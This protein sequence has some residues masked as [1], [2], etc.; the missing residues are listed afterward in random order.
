MIAR[1]KIRTTNV[2]II[3]KIGVK[4]EKKLYFLLNLT[5]VILNTEVS[6]CHSIPPFPMPAVNDKKRVYLN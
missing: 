4:T 5:Y 1:F 6:K 3:N 2:L